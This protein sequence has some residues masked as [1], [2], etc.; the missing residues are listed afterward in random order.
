[1]WELWLIIAL[2]VLLAV[3]LLWDLRKPGEQ[4]QQK[5][6]DVQDLLE[7][8]PHAESKKL[9]NHLKDAVKRAKRKR[10]K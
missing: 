8:D 4:P 7:R 6:D 1:M 2:I 3:V 10:K 5:D 9:I